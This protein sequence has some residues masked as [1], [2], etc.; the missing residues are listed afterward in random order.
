HLQVHVPLTGPAEIAGIP[1]PDTLLEQLRTNALIEPVVVDESGVPLA[2]GKATSALSP[3]IRR[4]VLL[5]DGKCRIPGC[6]RRHGLEAHH[7]K[8]RTWGG[9]D[10]LANLAAVCPTHH[11][12][13]IPH[14]KHALTGNP[15]Q[16]D[17]LQFTDTNDL[18]P[19]EP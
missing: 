18:P 6:A 7:L 1:I 9:T 3:K 12:Q 19:P 17:G 8:P 5:R 14:G 16:P 10:D 13:L 2:V 11:R 4:A 15:N